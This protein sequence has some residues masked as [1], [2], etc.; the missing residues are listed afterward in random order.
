MCG[1]IVTTVTMVFI[2]SVKNTGIVTL[3]LQSTTIHKIFLL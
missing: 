2:F 1:E 3:S